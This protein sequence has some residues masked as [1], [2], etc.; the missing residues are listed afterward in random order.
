MA[1]A[2]IRVPWACCGLSL[3]GGSSFSFHVRAHTALRA[4]AGRG[5]V[6]GLARP[7]LTCW[8]LS[9][10][11]ASRGSRPQTDRQ[12]G[13]CPAG[14]LTALSYPI[15]RKLGILPGHRLALENSVAHVFEQWP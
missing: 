5:A 6:E 1:P 2:L 14:R 3:P 13:G 15:S 8:G 9:V 10:G 11:G 7:S 12:A 4:C